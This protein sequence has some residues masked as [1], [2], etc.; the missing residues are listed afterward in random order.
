MSAIP[1]LL[2][3][4]RGR[5]PRLRKAQSYQAKELELHVALA[6]ALRRFIRPTAS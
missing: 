3:L 1:Q 5:R 6:G 4:A 2:L